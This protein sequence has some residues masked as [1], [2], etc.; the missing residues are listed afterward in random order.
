MPEKRNFDQQDIGES[1]ADRQRKAFCNMVDSAGGLPNVAQA[2]EEHTGVVQKWVIEWYDGVR[3]PSESIK[4]QIFTELR[5]LVKEARAKAK[6]AAAEPEEPPKL[7]AGPVKPP[8][9]ERP[10]PQASKSEKPKP[11]RLSYREKQKQ[12]TEARLMQDAEYAELYKKL[13]EK[14]LVTPPAPEKEKEDK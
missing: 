7:E 13:V 11:P 14:G 3:I 1:E 10:K 6:A 5:H 4:R 12:A 9:K 8:V 2:V